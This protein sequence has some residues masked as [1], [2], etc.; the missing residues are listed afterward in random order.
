[1]GIT[2]LHISHCEKSIDPQRDG[3]RFRVHSWPLIAVNVEDPSRSEGLVVG[4]PITEKRY[5]ASFIGAHM[6]H[7]RSDVRLKL[8]EAAKAD[9]GDDILVDLGG[10]WHFNKVV[11]QEQVANKSVKKED[12]D[13]HDVATRRYNEILS[14]SVF[15]LCPEG[16]GPN[17][18]RLW[19]SLAVGAI[20]VIVADEWI[21]PNLPV[22]FALQNCA[23]ILPATHVGSLFAHLRALSEHEVTA[24]QTACIAAYPHFRALR[25]YPVTLSNPK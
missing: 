15:S 8:L 4:K 20:P 13:K 22:P 25:T 5:L 24:R 12:L 3:Y 7:Y 2:D 9:G 17:T 14:D 18:L 16:A 23:V 1:L 6:P 11:Y 19:E 10:E 21:P